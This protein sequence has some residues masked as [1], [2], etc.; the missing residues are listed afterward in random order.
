MAV[1][2]NHTIV[3]SRDQAET[4]A[5]IAGVLGLPE[6]GRYRPVPRRADGQR[7][8]PRRRRPTRRRRARSTTPS[9]S[10]RRSSTRSGDGSGSGASSSTPTHRARGPA[11]STPTTGAGACT[12][13]NRAGTCWRSSPGPTAAVAELRNAGR[14]RPVGC[15]AMELNGISAI[16]TGGAS[17]LGAAT[18]RRLAADGATVVVVDLQDASRRGHRLRDRGRLRARRRHRRRAGT[19]GGGRRRRGRP[20]A[21]AGQLRRDRTAA[22]TVDRDGNPHDLGHFAKVVT[23]NLIGTFNCIRLAATAMAQPTRLDR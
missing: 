3:A 8:L 4:A 11:R 17:G 5:F 6:P 1:E 18:A 15:P 19:D 22:K 23:I 14:R 7:G 21:G 12:S 20:A 10:A 2:L 16:V 9:W 13:R